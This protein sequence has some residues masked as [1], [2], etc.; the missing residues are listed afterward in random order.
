MGKATELVPLKEKAPILASF[1]FL[2]ECLN[3]LKNTLPEDVQHVVGH[4]L[5][6]IQVPFQNVSPASVH[7]PPP[8]SSNSRLSFFPKLPQRHGNALYEAD[9]SK[10]IRESDFCHKK[11]L[12]TLH[13]PLG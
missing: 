6:T 3:Y 1:E 7:Y 10:S 4:I 5:L 12:D 9:R 13:L 2:I 8:P 11:A